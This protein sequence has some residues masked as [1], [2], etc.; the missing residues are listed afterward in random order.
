MKPLLEI[1]NLGKSFGTHTVIADV[2]FEVYP[3]RRL[4]FWGKVVL[5]NQHS[6]KL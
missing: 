4:L 2:N 1:R 3:K 5:E 6:F